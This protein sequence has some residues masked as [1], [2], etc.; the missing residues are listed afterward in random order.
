METLVSPSECHKKIVIS[1]IIQ[2]SQ[3]TISLEIDAR[4]HNRIIGGRGAAIRKIMEE[5]KVDVRFPRSGDENKNLVEITGDEDACRD[6]EDELLNLEEEYVS[7]IPP[8]DP[9]LIWRLHYYHV[10]L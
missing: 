8:P 6:C 3:T 7:L 9:T 10:D 2:E 5:F 4:V 1:H